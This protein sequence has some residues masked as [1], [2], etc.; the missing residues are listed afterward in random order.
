MGGIYAYRN[1]AE[2]FNKIKQKF[3]RINSYHHSFAYH[4][5]YSKF[6]FRLVFNEVFICPYLG[7]G[8]SSNID[9]RAAPSE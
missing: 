2:I 9:R 5:N 3:S 1:A 8:P 4:I 7:K 6:W